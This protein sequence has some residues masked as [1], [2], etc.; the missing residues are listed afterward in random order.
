MMSHTGARSVLDKNQR[1]FKVILARLLVKLVD[2]HV[3]I[4]SEYI[5]K[6]LIQ[7]LLNN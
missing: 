6:L 7:L 1:H 5:N 4:S 2:H 3:N